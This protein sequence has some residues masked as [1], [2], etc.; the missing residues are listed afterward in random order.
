[1]DGTRKYTKED[2]GRGCAKAGRGKRH[3]GLGCALLP[4]TPALSP[5]DGEREK[6]RCGGRYPGRR[7][8]TALPWANLR[9]SLRGAQDGAYGGRRGAG[10]L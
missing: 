3:A 6:N 1:M 10:D 5:S 4:L 8:R 7:P 9:L 2:G